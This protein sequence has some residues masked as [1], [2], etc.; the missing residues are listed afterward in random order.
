MVRLGSTRHV[1]FVLLAEFD[2]DTGASLARQFPQPLG[3]ENDQLREI[4]LLFL[5]MKAFAC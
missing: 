3:V 5:M 2:I 1:S 4:L